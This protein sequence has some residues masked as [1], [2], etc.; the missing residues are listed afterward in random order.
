MWLFFISYFGSQRSFKQ[1]GEKKKERNKIGS[2]L[3]ALRR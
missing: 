1:K 2:V 3:E